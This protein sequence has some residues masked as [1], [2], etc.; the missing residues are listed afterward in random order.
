MPI[1]NLINLKDKLETAQEKKLLQFILFLVISFLFWG[2]LTLNEEFQYDVVYPIKITNVPDSITLI[3]DAPNEL[4][5]NLKA[6][7]YSFFKHKLS[8]LPPILIDFNRYSK[9][10]RLS[11]GDIE[12]YEIIREISGTT[13][14]ANA[15]SPD[16]INVYYTTRPGKKVELKINAN[17]YIDDLFI[18]NGEIT[19]PTKHVIVYSIDPIPSNFTEVETMPI[20]CADLKNTTSI[21]V[22]VNTAKG[23]RAIPDSVDVNIPVEQLISKKRTATIEVLNI[24]VDRRLI[25]FPSQIE[26]NYLVPKSLFHNEKKLIRV[27]VDYR[28][29]YQN[30]NKLPVKLIDIPDNYKVIN[31]FT[32]SVEYIIEQ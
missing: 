20:N 25:I 13:S 26:L 19:S 6:K 10:N 9:R 1:K 16:S 17:K 3:T 14:Q 24:P 18:I 8:E 12:M 4:K 5:V 21:K 11:L 22:K 27:V 30:S 28:D 32:D 7:G 31:T 2:A 29:I 15:F 23:M